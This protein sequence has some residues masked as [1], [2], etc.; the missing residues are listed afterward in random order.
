MVHSVDSTRVNV[1]A[2]VHCCTTERRLA[3]MLFNSFFY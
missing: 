3:D 1:Y 2:Y